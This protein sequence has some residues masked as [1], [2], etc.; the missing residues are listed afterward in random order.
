MEESESTEATGQKIFCSGVNG[1]LP[2]RNRRHLKRSAEAD[3][4]PAEIWPTPSHHHDSKVR[5]HLTNDSKPVVSMKVN[6]CTTAT[7]ES[8]KDQSL[9][10]TSL[11]QDQAKNQP[12]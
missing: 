5:V 10:T 9:S 8:N 2:I 1:Q 7:T 3:S 4:A 12:L 6:Q 11:D